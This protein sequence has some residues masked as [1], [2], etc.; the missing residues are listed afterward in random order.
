MLSEAF[1]GFLQKGSI[2]LITRAITQIK[3]NLAHTAIC[4]LPKVN[5]PIDL[6][7]N[8]YIWKGRST[9]A[10]FFV[11]IPFVL[12]NLDIFMS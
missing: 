3:N 10:C 2:S 1:E 4:R 8:G 5:R 11:L 9:G 7:F 12:G 6:L